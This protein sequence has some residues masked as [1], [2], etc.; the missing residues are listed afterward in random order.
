M[1]QGVANSES[2]FIFTDTG[3]YGKQSDGDTFSASTLHH[4]LKD[5]ESTLP[6]PVIFEGSGTEMPFF[7]LGN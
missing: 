5:C 4:F 3:D 1:L 7:I 2:R 6:K